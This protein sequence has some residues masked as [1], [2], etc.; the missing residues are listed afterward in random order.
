M[1]SPHLPAHLAC[2]EDVLVALITL[3]LSKTRPKQWLEWTDFLCVLPTWRACEI[4]E[5]LDRLLAEGLAVRKTWDDDVA[6]GKSRDDFVYRVAADAGVS[7]ARAWRARMAYQA[8]TA[9]LFAATE[10]YDQGFLEESML[11]DADGDA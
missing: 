5:A 7:E 6:L 8:K 11:P 9:A 3:P 10:R 2:R 1:T 4:E